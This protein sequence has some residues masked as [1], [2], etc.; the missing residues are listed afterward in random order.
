M[1]VLFFI[2]VCVFI[3]IP[4]RHKARLVNS[5]KVTLPVPSPDGFSKGTAKDMDWWVKIVTETP[6]C[7]Y[8]FGP[9]DSA[10]EA[11]Q[12]QS[13]Y[14]EDLEEEGAS[15]IAVLVLQDRPETLTIYEE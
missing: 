14:V 12:Y 9:F 10:G 8:F 7:T 13:G 4:M 5:S 15:G 2:L 6:R 3:Q 11:K 1:F